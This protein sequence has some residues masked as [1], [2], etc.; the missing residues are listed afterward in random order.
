MRPRLQLIG[1]H[2]EYVGIARQLRRRESEGEPL[3][4]GIE[5]QMTR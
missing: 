5:T 1:R 3:A 2:L 4:V